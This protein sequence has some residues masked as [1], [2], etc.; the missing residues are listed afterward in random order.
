MCQDKSKRLHEK[1]VKCFR[2]YTK[3]PGGGLLSFYCDNTLPPIGVET[4]KSKK[5]QFH[6]LRSRKAVKDWA[7]SQYDF[8]C[9]KDVH[10]VIFECVLSKKLKG[11]VWGDDKTTKTVTGDVLTI[12]RE[13][14]NGYFPPRSEGST[15]KLNWTAA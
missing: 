14:G 3:Y 8:P 12:V 4:P 13:V 15:F 9:F 2:I 11:G 5:E 7:K 1:S 10:F 6:A